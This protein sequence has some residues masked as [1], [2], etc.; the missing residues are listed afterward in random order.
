[1]AKKSI[2]QAQHTKI[3]PSYIM[4]QDLTKQ[5]NLVVVN[6]L[7]YQDMVIVWANSCNHAITSQAHAVTAGI[8]KTSD[9]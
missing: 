8:R 9:P 4:A 2:T 6:L 5:T 1:M 7:S 3:N